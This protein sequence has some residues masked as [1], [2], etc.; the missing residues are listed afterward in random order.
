MKAFTIPLT[1]LLLLLA[2][3]NEASQP[4]SVVM[5]EQLSVSQSMDGK[6]VLSWNYTSTD[7]DG[8]QVSYK[9]LNSGDYIPLETVSAD[10]HTYTVTQELMGD[11]SYYFAVS[12]KKGSDQSYPATALYRIIPKGE[13]KGINILRSY[14]SHAGIMAEYEPQNLLASETKEIGLCLGT[15][16]DPTID[17]SNNLVV[18]APADRKGKQS[19]MQVI[20]IT[21]LP[22]DQ[23]T[24][25]LRAYSKGDNGK[26]IYSETKEIQAASQ[27]EAIKLEWTDVTPASLKGKVDVFKTTSQ[28]NGRPFNAWYAVGNPATTRIKR[29]DPKYNT[30]LS[31]QAAEM[32][33]VL[34][35]VNASY[36]YLNSTIGLYGHDG[37]KGTNYPLRG[38][39][40]ADH[41]EYGTMYKASRGFFGVTRDGAAQICWGGN[42]AD[43]TPH[44]YN[45]PMPILL[46]EAAY[47][48]FT[49]DIVGE[50][51]EFVPYY[52][53]SGGPVVLKD[54]QVPVDFEKT[55]EEAEYYVANYELMPYDIFGKNLTPDRTAVGIMEDG[56]I[57]LFVCDGRI[58]ESKGADLIELAQIMKGIGCKDALNLDG[59]GSTNMWVDGAIVNHKDIVKG[60]G[61]TRPIRSVIGFFEK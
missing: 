50:P 42:T 3:C 30:P 19:C 12:A 56:R 59:G 54:G 9:L 39:L 20:P 7:L 22:K 61:D 41:P 44:L 38:S 2:G 33:K 13:L 52:G 55:R 4:T 31:G 46:G 1:M 32:S 43:G 25:Y 45:H 28:L 35:L 29:N 53:V 24:L 51:I 17:D 60:T 47:A 10:T 15:A 5:P 49:P 40:K 14:V 11:K 21:R 27:P 34:V 16:K 26:T 8:F 48:D 36:F 23:S 18:A 57:V 58:P 6:V 37:L